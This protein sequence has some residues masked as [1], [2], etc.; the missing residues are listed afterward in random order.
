MAVQSNNLF[1]LEKDGNGDYTGQMKPVSKL[2]GGDSLRLDR[3]LQ[4]VSNLNLDGDIDVSGVVTLGASGGAADTTIRGDLTVDENLSVTGT[5]GFTGDVTLDGDLIVSGRAYVAGGRMQVDATISI[6][7]D[8]LLHLNA[9]PGGVSDGGLLVDRYYTAWGAADESGDAGELAVVSNTI[10]L[11]TVDLSHGAVSGVDD[12][13]NN[14]SIAITGGTGAGQAR[15]IL[16]FVGATGRATLDRKWDVAPDASSTFALYETPDRFA[17]SFFDESADEWVD[18]IVN[19][20]PGTTQVTIEGYLPRHLGALT[21]EGVA[22]LKGGATFLDNASAV[23]GTGSDLTIVHNGVNTLITSTTGDL[24][25]VNTNA[26]GSSYFKLGTNGDTNT[27]FIV[28]SST[29]SQLFSVRADGRVTTL[30]GATV[31]PIG[32]D[33]ILAGGFGGG[34]VSI[35]ANGGGAANGI[36]ITQ[37]NGA[38]FYI[39]LVPSADSARNLGASDKA[40]AT[41]YF[42]TLTSLN[43]ND[44]LALGTADQ[45]CLALPVFAAANLG[46]IAAPAAGDFLFDS[47]AAAPRFYDGA[48]WVTVGAGAGAATGTTKQTF[49]IDSD[50]S[51]AA[52]TDPALILLGGDGV[53]ANNDDLVRTKFLQD[54]SAE[55]VQFTLERNRHAGGYAQIAPN[56]Q[57]GLNGGT[58]DLDPVLQFNGGTGAGAAT[59]KIRLDGS[60]SDLKLGEDA[61]VVSAAVDFR[62]DGHIDQGA[63]KEFR[64]SGY[65]A[66]TTATPANNETFYVTAEGGNLAAAQQDCTAATGSVAKARLGG[67]Y[68]TGDKAVLPGHRVQAVLI[69]A[70]VAVEIGD[71]LYGSVATKGR[72]DPT[73]PQSG[74]K[75]R[76]G[77]AL[78]ACDGSGGNQT[79]KAILVSD[80][81]VAV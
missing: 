9:G 54:S 35:R 67:V 26:T 23:F 72:L 13:Y 63:T 4:L 27:S 70:N 64:E 37:S 47:D 24:G 59:A 32:G 33:L 39:D 18:G 2:A 51:E 20:D 49:T 8:N 56:F 48:Q 7:N 57:I 45:V 69:E 78:T 42:D 80:E 46:N 40:F 16:D 6:Y 1:V 38:I 76:C 79:V 21:A 50:A 12:A 34:S 68:R 14:W 53:A 28:K 58:A 36:D 71:V 62:A 22:A 77:I 52:D 60:A 43:A 19:Y 55:F 74:F 15:T 31:G 5:A 25:F 75:V 73:V 10:D 30:S 17:G 44:R 81:P 41:G 61:T 29:D 66:H 3:D 11:V 65:T